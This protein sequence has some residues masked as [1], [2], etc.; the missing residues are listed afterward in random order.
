MGDEA[1]SL[2]RT[3]SRTVGRYSLHTPISRGGMATIYVGTLMG[4]VGFSRTVAIKRLHEGFAQDPDFVAML[5]DEARLAGR[6]LHPNVVSIVDVVAEQGEAFLV[7]DY[8]AGEAVGTIARSIADKNGLIPLRILSAILTGALSGLHAAHEAKSD[9]GEP[10]LIV[11]RDMSPQNILLGADG[12]PRVIDF[13]VAKAAARIQVTQDGQVKG[14][15]RY[16]SPEQVMGGEVTRATDIY[17]VGVMLWELAT[18]L[19]LRD[20]ESTAQIAL[21]IISDEIPDP[22]EA[23]RSR[24]IA[25]DEQHEKYLPEIGRVVRRATCMAPENRYE[26]A[27]E[28]ARDLAES[29]PVATTAEIADWLEGV[30]GPALAERAAL[31]AEVEREVAD[32]SGDARPS[33]V[34]RALAASRPDPIEVAVGTPSGIARFTPK[35]PTPAPTTPPP[36]ATP[37]ASG[38]PNA[39]HKTAI[40]VAIFLCLGAFFLWLSRGEPRGPTID[41]AAPLLPLTGTA[42]VIASSSA[43]LPPD[44]AASSTGT[45]TPS[46]APPPTSKGPAPPP[47]P[48]QPFTYDEQGVKRYNPK[49]L[50]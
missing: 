49:C 48:C 19:K 13:G 25:F 23:L 1:K 20:G 44:A 14:K 8:V 5:L 6:I 18:G 40:L 7:M 43:P 45:T 31:V 37:A 38:G 32:A 33:Q 39:G 34:M 41:A 47:T 3:P 12:V 4:P 11:H 46:A 9:R 15:L 10:L 21:S 24:G 2:P 50:Q 22:M 30:A 28:M 16:M 26:S 29:V 17:A 42:S 36:E 27:K 35:P